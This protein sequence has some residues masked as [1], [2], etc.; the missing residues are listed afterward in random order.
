MYKEI[1][2][3][4]KKLK[5]LKHR[6]LKPVKPLEEDEEDFEQSQTGSQIGSQEGSQEDDDGEDVDENES[7][8]EDLNVDADAGIVGDAQCND[9]ELVN[10]GGSEQGGNAADQQGVFE[11]EGKPQHWIVRLFCGK[12]M[13]MKKEYERDLTEWSGLMS[14]DVEM[15]NSGAEDAGTGD[16]GELVVRLVRSIRGSVVKGLDEG[17][18]HMTLGEKSLIKVRYD[19]AYSSFSMGANIPPRSDLVFKVELLQINGWGAFGMPL[20][21]FKRFMRMSARMI[22]RFNLFWALVKAFERRTRFF[23]RILV[24]LRIKSKL[25]EQV[26]NRFSIIF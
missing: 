26:F 14:Y 7:E 25:S 20:R 11:V 6:I 12:V 3:Q 5:A 4:V 8:T 23:E 19:H 9:E 18:R 16:R 10:E 2:P 22:V 17:V 21:Q 24:F 13:G 15:D 1:F